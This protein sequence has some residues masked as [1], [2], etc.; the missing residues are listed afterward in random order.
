MKQATAS[1][2]FRMITE[3]Y[4]GNTSME[5]FVTVWQS[6]GNILKLPLWELLI[7]VDTKSTNISTPAQQQQ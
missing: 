2:A 4:S 1:S 7:E 6:T 5:Y 3:Y